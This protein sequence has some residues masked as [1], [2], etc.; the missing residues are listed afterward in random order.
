MA[1]AAT[2]YFK[3]YLAIYNMSTLVAHGRCISDSIAW[4]IVN[5]SDAA[6]GDAYLAP[7]S[8]LCNITAQSCPYKVVDLDAA[9]YPWNDPIV[10]TGGVYRDLFQDIL[11][12]S[13]L[14]A[15]K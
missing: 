8:V 15:S 4:I 6:H 13:T 10:N 12:F 1:E 7:N 9:D 5:L 11:D 2:E 14:L 3:Y